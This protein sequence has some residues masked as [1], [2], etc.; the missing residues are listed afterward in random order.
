[1]LTVP[2]C[3]TPEVCTSLEATA[4]PV[5]VAVNVTGLPE[6]DPELA[7]TLYVPGLLPNVKTVE[8]CP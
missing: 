8:A 3:P 5:A 7:A 1:M 2:L 6:S 4:A